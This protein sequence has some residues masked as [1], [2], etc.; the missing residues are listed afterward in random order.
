MYLKNY[1]NLTNW[2]TSHK[3]V[4]IFKKI[5]KTG[6]KIWRIL[7]LSVKKIKILQQTDYIIENPLPEYQLLF[8]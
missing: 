5:E 7:G 8:R 1:T 2:G 6:E 4:T 3:E